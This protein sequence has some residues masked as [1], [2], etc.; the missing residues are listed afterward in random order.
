MAKQSRRARAKLEC[1]RCQS[2]L[3]SF[4]LHVE[5]LKTAG[6]AE[7]DADWTRS[8]EMVREG[9]VAVNEVIEWWLSH[10]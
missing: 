5:N 3:E 4:I 8:F 1:Q 10:L 7:I 9:V 6:Y 2:S